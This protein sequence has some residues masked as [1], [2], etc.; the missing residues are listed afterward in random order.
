MR[1]QERLPEGS[2]PNNWEERHHLWGLA[3][4]VG[5]KSGEMLSLS[6]D[7]SDLPEETDGGAWTLEE[8]SSSRLS[9]PGT[10]TLLTPVVAAAGGAS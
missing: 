3:P 9:C 7:E 6:A 4:G 2:G 8:D 10:H 1:V 5:S